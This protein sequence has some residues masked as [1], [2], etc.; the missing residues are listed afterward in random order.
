MTDQNKNVLNIKFNEKEIAKTCCAT[1][2]PDIKKWTTNDKD[3]F[4]NSFNYLLNTDLS[5]LETFDLEGL[6]N[7]GFRLVY[8][9]FSKTIK[10]YHFKVSYVYDKTLC[11]R[12]GGADY[13]YDQGV[14]VKKML[15]INLNDNQLQHLKFDGSTKFINIKHCMHVSNQHIF[16]NI[17]KLGSFQCYKTLNKVINYDLD[18]YNENKINE[19]QLRQVYNTI[20]TYNEKNIHGNKYR[21]DLFIGQFFRYALHLK[22]NI[23]PIT[24]STNMH[25]DVANIIYDYLG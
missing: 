22:M 13:V 4:Y 23:D 2:S 21:H 6:E 3:T 7:L 9:K 10:F 11:A 19:K 5:K 17:N 20:K 12:R 24:T 16:F 8:E 1:W 18:D 25:K 14:G 15:F